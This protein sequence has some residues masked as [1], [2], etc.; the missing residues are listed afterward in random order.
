MVHQF[1]ENSVFALVAATNA[2]VDLPRHCFQLSDGTW[3]MPR[4]PVADEYGIWGKWLGSIRLD[5]LKDANLVLLVEETSDRP[6]IFGGEH[7]RL[8]M[9]VGVLY[10]LLHLGV[11]IKTF[12][13]EAAERL[14]GSS[15]DGASDVRSVESMRRFHRTQESPS[16][17]ITRDWL[18]DCLVLC[19][20]YA[21]M[22]TDKTQFRRIIRGL[23]T[24][25]KGKEEEVGQERLHQFVRS[26]EALILPKQGETTKQF[27][28]RC[29]TFACAGKDTRTLFLEA[30]SIRSAAEHLNRW[31]EAEAARSYSPDERET[32]CWQ[33]TL[34]MERLACDAYSRLLGNS[35]LRDHFRTDD[36]IAEFWKLQDGQRC[37]IWGPPLDL[38]AADNSQCSRRHA[39]C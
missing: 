29:R 13:R 24:L 4:L 35:A 11:G 18:E 28:H 21:D 1:Q 3:I 20:G 33:R 27:A 7:L 25:F 9:R 17:P 10:D 8:S 39:A 26:L 2:Y 38:A 23:N 16:I 19:S 36:T 31:D 30:F 14:V 12:E 32:V 34:Q 15:V 5:R 37:Q 6:Y 22:E